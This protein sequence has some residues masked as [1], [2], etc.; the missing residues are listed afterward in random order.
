MPLEI[1]VFGI[2]SVVILNIKHLSQGSRTVPEADLTIGLDPLHLV[3]QVRPH[4][5]HACAATNEHHLG[6]C[7]LREEFTERPIN[8]HFV[9]G[10]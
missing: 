9:A 6:L 4:R 7:F 5:S 10:L 8:V 2:E 1:I 3:K